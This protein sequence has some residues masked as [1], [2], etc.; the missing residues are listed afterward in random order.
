MENPAIQNESRKLK[1]ADEGK[2]PLVTII[3]QHKNDDIKSNNRIENSFKTPD[4]RQYMNNPIDFIDEFERH[5]E[6]SMKKPI[7]TKTKSQSN[8]AYNL[9]KELKSMIP[10]K[11]VAF[12]Y[13]KIYIKDSP[14]NNIKK[15]PIVF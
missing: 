2:A 6:V 5:E 3:P 12:S 7:P 10:Y 9:N 15:V 14:Y 1:W 11:K 13:E 8:N 4:K